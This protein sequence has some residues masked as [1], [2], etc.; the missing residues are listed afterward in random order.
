MDGPL[1]LRALWRSGTNG[2]GVPGEGT[3]TV[4]DGGNLVIGD[5]KT[6][7]WKAI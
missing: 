2:L 5:G 4:E 3:A 7:L 6:N 1:P